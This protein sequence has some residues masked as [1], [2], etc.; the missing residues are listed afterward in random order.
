MNTIV[1]VTGMTLKCLE[2]SNENAI[3]NAKRKEADK[4]YYLKNKE[5]KKESSNQWYLKNKEKRK[6]YVLKNKEK[7]KKVIKLWYLKNKERVNELGKQWCLKNKERKKETTKQW[8]LKNKEWRNEV[9]R[10]WRLKNKEHIRERNKKRRKNDSTYRL[11]INLKRR[12]LL[13]LKGKHK[14][15]NTMTLLGVT[16]IELVWKHLE[17]TF[18][19]GMTRENHGKWHID[20]IR[21]CASFDLSKPEEQAKCFHYSNLQ[22][23]WSHENLSKGSKILSPDSTV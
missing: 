10:Q 15:A 9:S 4:R 19:P 6:Q 18:K 22:A 12:T 1:N 20:H 8:Q 3:K 14:N 13:A 23:L 16:N 5:K 17:L 2:T 21:P 7:I 11:K